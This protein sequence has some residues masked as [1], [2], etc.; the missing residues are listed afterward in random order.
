MTKSAPDVAE[1]DAEIMPSRIG[2]ARWSRPAQEETLP[3]KVS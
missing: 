1:M 3:P 2:P